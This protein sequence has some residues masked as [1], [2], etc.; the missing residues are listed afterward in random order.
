M[1]Q[2]LIQA[3]LKEESDIYKVVCVVPMM[4]LTGKEMAEKITG[5]KDLAEEPFPGRMVIPPANT[6]A[7][8]LFRL[9]MESLCGEKGRMAADTVQASLLPQDINK[10]IDEGNHLAG[11]VFPAFGRTSRNGTTQAIWPEEGAVAIPLVALLRADAPPKATQILDVIFSNLIQTR[12][13]EEGLFLA[14]RD[15]VPLIDEM[16][17]NHNHLA[18]CGWENHIGS[19]A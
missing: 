16:V 19:H 14:I 15:D 5:W 12:L 17:E 2:E 3:G 10:S 6:P 9:Y 11:M 4:I 1:R 7:P 8:D 13:A 18:W